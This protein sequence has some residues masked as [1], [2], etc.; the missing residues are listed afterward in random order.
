MLYIADCLRWILVPFLL[1]AGAILILLLALLMCGRAFEN[2]KIRARARL[3]AK[4]RPLVDA[5]LLPHPP[6]DV[7]RQLARYVRTHADLLAELLVAPARFATGSL[8]D[9]LRSAASELG[10]A[11]RWVQ[12]LSDR[13]WWIRADAARALGL[14]KVPSATDPLLAALDDQE[15]EVR[16]AAVEALGNIGDPRTVP[17][18]VSK[19]PEQSRHQRVRVI[20]AL[21]QFGRVAVPA[22]LAYEQEHPGDRAMVAELLGII[23]DSSAVDHLVRW[24]GDEDPTVRGASIGALGAIGLDERTYYYALRTLSDA[25][26]QVRAVAATALGRSGRREAAPYLVARL[27]DEWIVAAPSA[28]ALRALGTPGIT[29]LRAHAADEGM[30]G[31]LARQV[32]FDVGEAMT[33]PLVAV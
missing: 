13:R 18:I 21:H 22:L 25:E 31:D 29:A 26:P 8:I 16:A 1:L 5:L 3:I 7:T 6:A 23:A 19:L 24:T 14:L 11:G 27:T 15:E 32:L 12:N 30:P 28:T 33:P 10:L 9:E 4:C 17:V 20:E 2:I